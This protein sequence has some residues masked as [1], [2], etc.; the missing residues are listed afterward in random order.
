M[1]KKEYKKALIDQRNIYIDYKKKLDQELKTI[2]E[3]SFLKQ[4]QYLDYVTF[5]L[6]SS[7]NVIKSN[8][9]KFIAYKIFKERTE[10]D[11]ISICS[12]L[13]EKYDKIN[14]ELERSTTEYD[15]ICIALDFINSVSDN[16]FE[17]YLSYKIN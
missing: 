4:A 12:L 15:K 14:Q 1:I 10:K 6:I 7:D 5:N 16:E 8:I 3:I 9:G 17:K 2:L 13:Y 11:L